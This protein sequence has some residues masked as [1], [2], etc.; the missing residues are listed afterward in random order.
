MLVVHSS[1]DRILLGRQKRFPAGLYSCLA[2]FME[3]GE[4]VEDSVRREVEEEAGVK[5]DSV[6]FYGSQPWPFPYSLMLGCIAEA[7]TEH[8]TID[9]KEIQEAKWFTREEVKE[10]VAKGE[11]REEGISVPPRMAIAGQMIAAFANSDPITV[12]EP[13]RVVSGML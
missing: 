8:I 5:V 11:R 3:H 4:G 6:R 2:G 1:G 12:F 13:K 9:E 10:M 7:I